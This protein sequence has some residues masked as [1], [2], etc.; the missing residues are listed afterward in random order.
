[1]TG[2]IT[3]AL[4]PGSILWYETNG[5]VPVRIGIPSEI[6]PPQVKAELEEFL[7]AITGLADEPLAE[8]ITFG[9]L[10]EY[11]PSAPLKKRNKSRRKES[12]PRAV[13][14]QLEK[15]M[16][17]LASRYA[18]THDEKIKAEIEVLSLR[19]ANLWNPH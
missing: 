16:D 9:S 1:M 8:K 19:L 5:P 6:T 11:E 13:R 15:R 7:G 4:K 14:E 3:M 10:Y 18:E 12:M 2:D 17:E